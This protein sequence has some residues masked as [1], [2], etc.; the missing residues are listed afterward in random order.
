MTCPRRSAYY[1]TS[2]DIINLLEKLLVWPQSFKRGEKDRIRRYL[3]P[4]SPTTAS[5]AKEETKQLFKVI[6]GFSEPKPF[7]IKKDVKVYEWKVLGP[8]L[9]KVIDKYNS[10]ASKQEACN[11][12]PIEDTL[13]P[14]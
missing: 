11:N 4:F 10:N 5:K 9:K 7:T 14:R 13:Q 2:C 8:A 12:A 3:A 6:V 1:V